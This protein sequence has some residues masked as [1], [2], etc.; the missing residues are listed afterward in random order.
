MKK[1]LAI[2]PHPDDIELGCFGTMCRY[3]SEGDDIN[4]LVLTKGEGGSNGLDR[5]N[6][7]KESASLLKCNLFIENLKDKY[8]S[9][10]VETISVIEKYIN[11]IKPDIVFIPSR[12][13][14][15]QD[16]RAIHYASL[17]ATR[18]INEIYIY[19]SPSTN[20][21]F[22][23]NYYVDITDFIETK[24]KAVKIHSSQG[25]KVYMA[26]R[27]VKG[28]AEYRAFDIFRNDKFFEAFEL[29]RSIK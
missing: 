20:T 12:Y 28:L 26:D 7:A 2:G 5:T 14:T 11:K 18:L 15:H 3:A 17:V 1:I 10:G 8:V 23:P 27:A 16:H 25:G 4:F 6:E 13:D 19:Q 9:E 24:L 22:K 29:F 21:D